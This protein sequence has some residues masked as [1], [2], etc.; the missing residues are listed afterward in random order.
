MTPHF[1]F[2]EAVVTKTG[3]AN[4]PAPQVA[5]CMG[6]AAMRLERVRTLLQRPIIISSWFR[7]AAVN[8]AVGGSKNSDHIGGH[9]ID[10]TCRAFGSDYEVAC[11]IRESNIE[12]DQLILEYGWIHISFAP[13]LRRQCMTKKSASTPYLQGLVN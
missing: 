13:A 1:T 3:L 10:F 5:A 4:M 2:A 11:A 8:K 12:F 9:A 7:S 6:V